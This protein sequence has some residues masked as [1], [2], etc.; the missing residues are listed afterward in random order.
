MKTLDQIR[1]EDASRQPAYGAGMSITGIDLSFGTIFLVVFKVVVS[2]IILAIP[3]Y[4][5]LIVLN[6]V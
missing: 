1:A 5:L 3:L 2:L 4:V 6:V